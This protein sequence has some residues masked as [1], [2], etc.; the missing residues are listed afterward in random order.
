MVE[1]TRMFLFNKLL[2]QKQ[3]AVLRGSPLLMEIMVSYNIFI[4]V[5]QNYPPIFAKNWNIGFIS[6]RWNCCRSIWLPESSPK[7]IP[8]PDAET[9]YFSYARQGFIGKAIARWALLLNIQIPDQNDV[10]QAGKAN[11]C[12]IFAVR[13]HNEAKCLFAIK[14]GQ[15][16]G[17]VTVQISLPDIRSP[18]VAL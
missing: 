14:S 6:C 9:T 2:F 8:E 5:F 12:Q 13:G 16:S 10:V 15:L 4:M 17:F 11:H 1:S 18:I 7:G 3:K